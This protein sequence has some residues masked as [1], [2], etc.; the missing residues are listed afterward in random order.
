MTTQSTPTQQLRATLKARR[1]N[2]NASDASRGALLMRG[3]LF[4]W[5]ATTRTRLQQAGK[6]APETIAAYWALP[7]EPELT[8]LLYQWVQ[9]EGY[10]VCLPAV[11][12]ENEPLQ[13]RVW[14]PET[15]MVAGA[16]G[17]QEPAG[18]I[19]PAPDVVLVPTLG[20]T[21]QG[22]R[23]GYGK[24]FYDRTLA[25]L[26]SSGHSFVSIGVAWAVGDLSNDNYAPQAHD[27]KLD[28]VITDKGW[29][30]PAPV[31]G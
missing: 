14:T 23:I 15:P 2:Q 29:A 17:I 18:E 5:L 25:A 12:G 31:L 28:A 4:T 20:F 22:D 3:R 30:V 7:G 26:R 19:A 1:Q 21:R 16:Y 13:F 6:P 24:G 10:R 11:T 9:E 8:P 27:Q